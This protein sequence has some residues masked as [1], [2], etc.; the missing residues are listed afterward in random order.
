MNREKMKNYFSH[1]LNDN[2][3]EKKFLSGNDK[4]FSVY[5]RLSEFSISKKKLKLLYLNIIKLLCE[6]VKKLRS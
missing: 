6:L 4:K 2:Y 3:L 1:T 5:S